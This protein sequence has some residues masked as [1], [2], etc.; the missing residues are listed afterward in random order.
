MS[1]SH[2]N[3]EAEISWNIFSVFACRWR[4]KVSWENLGLLMT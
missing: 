2:V 1:N 3:A 4:K